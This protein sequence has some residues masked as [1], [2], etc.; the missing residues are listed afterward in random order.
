MKY[1]VIEIQKAQDGAIGNFVWAFDTL[2][3]AESKYHAVLAVA[4]TSTVYVHSCSLLNETGFC[5]KAQSYNH[6]PEPEPQPE[7]EPEPEE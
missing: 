5:V 4:A 7:P 2:N 6:I 1:L 3:E